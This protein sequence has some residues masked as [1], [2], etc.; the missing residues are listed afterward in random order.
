M[1]NPLSQPL[2]M[3]QK[4]AQFI[5][6]QGNEKPQSTLVR[7]AAWLCEAYE[8]GDVCL[9]LPSLTGKN[10]PH[11]SLPTPDLEAW[12]ADLL[13]SDCV[14]KAGAL[15]P[16]IL[17]DERVYL[18]R[19]WRDEF[20]VAQS[21][22][23]CLELAVDYDK[24]I[25][26]QGLERLFQAKSSMQEASFDGQKIAATLAL[27]QRFSVISGG[28]G[29]G[30][31][32]SLLKVLALLLEQQ[33]NMKIGMA[34]P[35]GKAAARMA[36]SVRIAKKNLH[37]DDT[38]QARIPEQASTLHRLLGYSP[39]GFRHNAQ[40][41]LML[42]CLVIDEA[43]MIDLPMM[44]RLLRALPTTTRIILLGDR[45]Q[46]ASVEAGSVLGDITGHGHAIAYQPSVAENLANL[47]HTDIDLLPTQENTPAISHAIA[48]LHTSYRFHA[49]SDIGRLARSINA[50]DV[51]QSLEILT[52]A[53]NEPNGQVQWHK[54]ININNMLDYAVQVYQNYI[55]CSNV[56]D[57]MLAFEKFRVLCAMRFD[58]FGIKA[59]NQGI[60][61][62]LLGCTEPI[63][64]LCVQGMPILISSNDY[65][66]ELFNGD[67]GLIWHNEA[68]ELRAYFRQADDTLRDISLQALPAYEAAWAMT[69]HKSQGSEFEQ[70]MMV[71]PETA[72]DIASRE[73]LY[74]AVTRAKEKFILFGSQTSVKG[75][76]SQNIQRNSGLAHRLGWS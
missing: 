65:E 70:V 7:T 40:Y 59:I 47:S 42:D 71:L 44:A 57:A 23:N 18:H 39:R 43:S 17:D 76:I 64:T 25:L 12:K 61:K 36:E 9:H 33:V 5:A 35:T 32:T 49:D 48:I 30:K 4:F 20:D 22:L 31:T 14:A 52:H 67:I 28:P 55:A 11:T 6:K 58:V 66:L 72:G 41:P 16:I 46:L 45:D 26:K 8:A 54:N 63:E 27:T 29:T 37:L 74:T 60:A 62:Q 69:V 50:G 24:D 38:I 21:I 68:G 10:W 13:A 3:A 56:S 51:Q 73:L 75:S 34:A 15:C 19:L 2:T 53:Q 1:H